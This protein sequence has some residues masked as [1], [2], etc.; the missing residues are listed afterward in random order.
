MELLV[1]KLIEGISHSEIK[2]EYTVYRGS[3]HYNL[4]RDTKEVA[5]YD[6]LHKAIDEIVVRLQLK[7]II[8]TERNEQETLYTGI[9]SGEELGDLIFS[10]YDKSKICQYTTNYFASPYYWIEDRWVKTGGIVIKRY[11]NSVLG[12]IVRE[13]LNTPK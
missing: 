12:S 9:L 5:T 11:K 1:E 8:V 2:K 10:L 3:W 13:R 7:E 6:N 4:Y